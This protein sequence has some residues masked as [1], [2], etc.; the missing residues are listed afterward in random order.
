MKA[1]SKRMRLEMMRGCLDVKTLAQRAKL[2]AKTVYKALHGDS[3]RPLTIAR[4][5]RVLRV[6][7][8]ELVI[9]EEVAK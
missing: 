9:P 2:P 5:A 8:A 7:P 3:V 4:I 6:D 1:N